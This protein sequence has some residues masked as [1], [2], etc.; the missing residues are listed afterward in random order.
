[1]RD[2]LFVFFF[3]FSLLSSA[4]VVAT[5][6][7]VLCSG[8]EGEVPIT[9]TATSFAVDL[10]DANIYTDDIFGGVIEMGFDFDFYGNT[11]NQVVLSS[12]NYLTFNTAVAGGGSGWAIG[13]AVP[14]NFDAPMNAILCPWQDIY[15]GVNGN[16]TI[17]YATTG[18]APN[19]VFIASFCGIPMFSCTDICYSSQIKLYETTNVIETH[20]AQKV[21]C[22]TW[23]DGA[24]IHALHN[25]NGTIAH[26]VTGIDGIERNFP[27]AWTCEDDG[28][29]FT[30]NGEN[31]YV[32]ENIEFAPAVAGTDIIWQDQFGNQIGTGSEITVFPA[33]DVTYTAGASLCGDAG[34][35]C[36]FEGGIEGDEVSIL[37]ESI[38]ITSI[39][40]S[41]ATCDDPNAGAINVVAS[42]TEPFEYVW[43]NNG[44]PLNQNTNS[45]TNLSS[46]NYEL[47]VSTANGCSEFV[48]V[49]IDSDGEPVTPANA[50]LDI[51]TCDTEFILSANAP[52]SNESGTW[53]LV[54]G[55]GLIESDDDP[56][57]SVYN[58]G[59]GL[60]TFA[61]TLENEC[62]PSTDEVVINVIDGAPTIMS[63]GTLFCLEQIPLI[64][65]EWSGNNG[66]WVVNPQEGVIID[67]PTSNSTFAT[68]STYG[69]YVFSFEGICGSDSELISMNSSPPIVSGPDEVYC[70]ES[71]QLEAVVT[72]DPGLWT[73][74]GP[75]NVFFNDPESLNPMVTADQ[76]GLYE[77][78]FSSCGDSSSVVVELVIPEP[79]IED[80]GIIYCSLEAEINAIS[81]F[82]GDWSTGD[83][84]AGS[85][86]SIQNNG[87]SAFV[88]VSDYGE[89]QVI[90]SSCGVDDTL[91][92][93]FSPAT[94]YIISSEHLHC[95]L[96]IDL[97]AIS[98]SNNVLWEQV[99]GPSIAE[100]IDPYSN[101]TQA[102]VSE[103]GLYSF[104]F[105]AC[106]YTEI[107]EI[108]LSCPLTV[109]NSFSPNGDGLND[110][111]QIQDL[112]P[113]VYSESILYIYNKWGGIVYMDSNYGLNNDWW[114]GQV[115]FHN[116]PFSNI[117]PG[118]EWDNNQDYVSDGVYFYALEVYNMT[119]RQKEFYSGDIMIFSQ[120][121]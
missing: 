11:Y 108:G 24:A 40:V 1:M 117:L 104:S 69:D 2:L 71:F 85:T 70:L 57:T 95:L 60:N 30:P 96:T 7:T 76:Y 27:N 113:N 89:Y 53:T 86:I 82:S 23:N 31:D 80:P 87:N 3:L 106:D 56:A 103:F 5:G 119:I 68:V 93:N 45:V 28:W 61:W 14:N 88:N 97:S 114:D 63:P 39:D 102:I 107:I 25:D 66:S 8:Q 54:S 75:G 84:P 26:V 99:S 101:S 120:K 72:G 55:T 81:D 73:V 59:I 77:F 36:G 110:L 34:D 20:I 58:L 32:I 42:G 49:F 111:F 67:D 92:I 91:S 37:F 90:F 116:R 4:Q 29:R 12:N 6:D 13:A 79:Y 109:P 52:L 100:I 105:S 65:N 94:P 33:G 78:F 121:Q 64:A 21:L 22:T 112:D 19:R 46:G 48:E 74:I 83:I 16:G 115:L 98:P 38:Q 9:L 43:L 50:G 35:W 44:N 17:Q 47:F 41:N 118:R 10:T 15:P 18:E 62:G 51:E